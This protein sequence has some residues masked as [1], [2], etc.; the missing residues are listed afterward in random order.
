MI[1][2]EFRRYWLSAITSLHVGTGQGIGFVDLPVA[3]ERV[4]DWPFVPGSSVKGVVREYFDT[5]R[6]PEEWL[7]LAFGSAGSSGAQAGAPVFAD[8]GGGQAGALVFTD[9]SI[10]CL[11]IR[12]LYG[13]F[14]YVSA[15][16]VLQRL[17]RGTA[18]V[19]PKVPECG[20]AQVL[21]TADSVLKATDN[22]R[23]YL[24]DLDFDGLGSSEATVWAEYIGEALFADDAEWKRVFKGRFLIIS[25][26]NFQ[27]LCQTATEVNPRIRIDP[28]KGTVAEGAYW[29]EENLPAE[30]IMSGLVW[31]DASP[32]Y[33][34]EEMMAG[35]PREAVTLQL[36][37][38]AST[39]HGRVSC[40][41]S[42]KGGS[43]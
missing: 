6:A 33:T 29:Y 25:D 1:G 3:R 11:P 31:C 22:D 40:R 32:R 28:K 26:N 9:S 43:K 39:G 38:H 37:G 8:N 15:P 19:L 42:G 14:A 30:T 7:K 10:V 5:S 23:V 16:L 13:T 27:F 2:N 21:L 17:S 34:G 20:E 12:S 36:G 35:L 4:T 24:E 18:E 41:F